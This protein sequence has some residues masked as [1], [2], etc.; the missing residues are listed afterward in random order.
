MYVYRS[1]GSSQLHKLNKFQM[2]KEV[3]SICIEK[4]AKYTCPACNTKTCSVECVKRHK[5]RLECSGEVDPTKFVPN[6][7]LSSSPALVNRDY[8]YLLNFERKVSLG[9]ADIKTN[10]RNIFKRNFAASNPNKRPKPNPETVDPRIDQVNR[11]F[12]NDPQISIKRENTLIIHL[13]SGM[14]RASQN[15]SGFDKKAE[16]Y[17]WTVEWLPV[18]SSGNARKSF[19]SFRLKEGTILRDSVPIN[20]LQN[21]VPDEHFTKEK[22]HFYLENCINTSSKGRSII[23]LNPE[24]TLGFALADKV[25]LEY[26]KICITF[27]DNIWTEYIQTENEAYGT[28]PE[29]VSA[30]ESIGDTSDSDNEADSES[31][32]E[33]SSDSDDSDEAPEELSSKPTPKVDFKEDVEPEGGNLI[34]NVIESS[35]NVEVNAQFNVAESI[36]GETVSELTTNNETSI[37]EAHADI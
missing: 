9:K 16:S 18:D 25:V 33:L 36:N 23:K 3:C 11:V 21:A 24:R 27:D 28:H 29:S 13:P 12:P 6:K 26:P 34:D 7:D 30:S 2:S 37:Q 17:I 32:S 5:L 4:D 22:L 10:A 19:I 15:K 35:S 31:D 14:S 1:L 8:N 20:V